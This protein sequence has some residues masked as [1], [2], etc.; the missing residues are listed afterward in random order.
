M[1]QVFKDNN[2]KLAEITLNKMDLCVENF[3][4]TWHY[5]WK[6]VVKEESSTP[7]LFREN[8]EKLKSQVWSFGVTH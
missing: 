8:R 3:L 7:G 5:F 4:R 2:H 6:G 1:K